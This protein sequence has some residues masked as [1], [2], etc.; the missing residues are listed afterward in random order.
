MDAA[1]ALSPDKP[2]T[3]GPPRRRPRR[4]AGLAAVVGTLLALLAA[5]TPAT[6][7]PAPAAAPLA[8]EWHRLNPSGTNAPEHERVSCTEGQAWR[9]AYDQVPE[10]TL[11]AD[12]TVGSFVGHTVTSTW[13]CPEWFADHCEDVVTVVSGKAH[14]T[15][16]DGTRFTLHGESIVTEADGQEV[17]WDHLVEFG[18]AVPYFRTFDEAVIAAGFTPPYLFDGSNWPAWDGIVIP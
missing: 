16:A 12:A 8:G 7:A 9:C 17:R 13:Q 18:V 3:S 2:L 15:L 4:V 10:P 5:L 11:E 1:A 6:A 14:V